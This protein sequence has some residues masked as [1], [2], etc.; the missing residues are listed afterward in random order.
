MIKGLQKEKTGKGVA[1]WDADEFVPQ[2][3]C[4]AVAIDVNG[5]LTAGTSTGG[6]TNKLTGCIGD[7]PTLGTSFWAEE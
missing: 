4:G 3:T 7:T 6:I 5:V 1:S 2:G